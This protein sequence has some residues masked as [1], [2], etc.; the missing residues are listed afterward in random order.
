M[1]GRM[2]WLWLTA[3]VGAPAS[4]AVRGFQFVPP[5]TT[6]TAG[7]PV[8]WTNEDDISHAVASGTPDSL[9][10]RFDGKLDRAGTMF[11]RLFDRPGVYP[12]HCARHPFM[13]GV[14]RVVS[15]GD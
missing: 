14:V 15:K 3:L 12:Y 8:V 4:I 10:G 11:T 5:E 7:T 2:T 1:A 13:R 9:D 6:V